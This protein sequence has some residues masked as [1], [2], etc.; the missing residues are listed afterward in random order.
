M[1]NNKCFN[2]M[3][4]KLFKRPLFYLSLVSLIIICDIIME[5]GLLTGGSN[6]SGNYVGK[7]ENWYVSSP[8]GPEDALPQNYN[9]YLDLYCSNT[10]I[11]GDFKLYNPQTNI[12]YTP[13]WIRNYACQPNS[14]PPK[15]GYIF[16]EERSF[17]NGLYAP[18]PNL[19]SYR[20]TLTPFQEKLINCYLRHCTPYVIRFF[21]QTILNCSCNQP[22]P[23][24]VNPND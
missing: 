9:Y 7:V 13:L 22:H 21:G 5:N 24:P 1:V 23:P 6:C 10:G 4:S 20:L 16:E 17:Y 14:W 19:Y 12:C 3:K 11:N 18:Y 2:T 8:C 15:N